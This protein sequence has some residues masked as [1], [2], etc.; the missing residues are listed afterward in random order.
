MI[1]WLNNPDK[2]NPLVAVVERDG[3]EFT[4]QTVPTRLDL[5][6]MLP[7]GTEGAEIGVM[8]GGFANEILTT[9]VRKL[10]LIDA[11]QHVPGHPDNAISM[12]QGG[13]NCNETTV[14]TRFAKQIEQRRVVVHRMFS[15]EAARHFHPHSL[16]W[17]FID[18]DHTY[19]AVLD[20]LRTWSSKIKPGGVIMGHDYMDWGAAIELKFG[21]I[22]AVNKFCAENGWKITHLTSKDEWPSYRLERV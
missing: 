21:V 11:W 20:D 8:Q 9:P 7:L 17:I 18:A 10:H 6:K 15:V 16:D 22:P 19:Q 13:H 12:S 1:G 14:I 5:I 2:D 3:K 4:V